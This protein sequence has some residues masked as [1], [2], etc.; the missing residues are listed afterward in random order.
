METLRRFADSTRLLAYRLAPAHAPVGLL[1][2]LAGLLY[3]SFRLSAVTGIGSFGGFILPALGLAFMC[4]LWCAG[5]KGAFISASFGTAAG[6]LIAGQ[7][8]GA[9]CAGL[10]LGAALIVMN[11]PGL[12]GL[13]RHALLLGAML[14]MLPV[15]ILMRAWKEI[16]PSDVAVHLGGCG[17]TLFIAAIETRAVSAGK[18][19]KKRLA[20]TDEQT[21]AAAFLAGLTAMAFGGM[22]PLG[23]GLGPAFAALFCLAAA[24]SKGA[25]AVACAAIVSGVRVMSTGGE[26]IFIAVLCSCTLTASLFRS[27]GKWVTAAGF[28]I[29]AVLFFALIR[30]T[31]TLGVGEI[32][33]SCALFMLIPRSKLE[34]VGTDG[35]AG[36]AEILERKLVYRD[37]KLSMLS[38]VLARL[39]SLFEDSADPAE[40]YAA[41]QFSGVAECLGRLTAAPAATIG[42]VREPR[43]KLNFGS[44]VCPKKGSD[45]AGDSLCIRD[46]D[47]LQLAVISDGMGSGAEAAR[48]SSQT[49]QLLADLVT[50]GFKLTEASECVNRLLLLRESGEM[51]AT[52][53]AILF[54][55]LNGRMELVKHGAPPSYI[56]RRGEVS[57]LCE[58]ALPVGIVEEAF[59]A[60]CTARMKRGD[61]IVMMSDGAAD[62]FGDAL[63]ESIRDTVCENE[64]KLAAKL[65]VELAART[66]GGGDDMTVIVA[67]AE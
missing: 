41:R 6:C 47:G 22:S 3:G 17:L 24:Y 66:G 33:V 40:A 11:R 12:I 65:L 44:A 55:P 53:D 39:A 34:L 54:D 45:T 1:P 10:Y 58:E 43:F 31:G 14:V 50:C 7:Y 26:I 19:L 63:A 2:F 37:Y 49:V 46:F 13:Y 36:R 59:P 48:E 28:A 9:V 18:T 57:T 42:E 5:M 21:V 51:Y 52:V 29:P 62:A 23:V 15:G 20:V 25:A 38:D 64:P 56:V 60:V 16:S 4:A 30:G 8:A 27:F 67:A 35:A 32:L 61:V